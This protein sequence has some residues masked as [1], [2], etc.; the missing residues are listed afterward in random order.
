M[1][2]VKLIAARE[3]SGKDQSLK[4][5]RNIIQTELDKLFQR[6]FCFD[7]DCLHQLVVE[8]YT[9]TRDRTVAEK[10]FD[11][12]QTI[13]NTDLP[14]V[15]FVARSLISFECIELKN[16]DHIESLID[17]IKNESL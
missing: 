4:I 12:I 15:V 13:N 5:L 17:V 14:I 1:N 10:I 16:A 3:N 8:L 6:E 9:L 7:H 2:H 11:C